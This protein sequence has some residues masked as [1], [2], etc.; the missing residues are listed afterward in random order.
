ML[1]WKYKKNPIRWIK[2]LLNNRIFLD[3]SQ[4]DLG[5]EAAL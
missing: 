1:F 2:K 3:F 5:L 4:N